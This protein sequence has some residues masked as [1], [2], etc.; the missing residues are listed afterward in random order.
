MGKNNPEINPVIAARTPTFDA[1]LEGHNLW[2]NQR[3]EASKAV[4]IPL[5][6]SLGVPGVPQSATGQTTLWTGVNAAKAAGRHVNAFP[7]QTLR[8]I[9]AEHSIFKSLARRGYRVTFANA[10]RPQFFEQW[11][12]GKREFSTSTLTATA[13]GLRIRNL[14]DLIAG[15]AVYQDITKSFWGQ[16]WRTCHC[17]M[18]LSC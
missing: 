15:N 2:G 17:T 16:C 8:E 1:L 6:A 4:L 3:L 14:E 10:F 7:N 12:L 13:A 11:E 5:D 18:P 9:I